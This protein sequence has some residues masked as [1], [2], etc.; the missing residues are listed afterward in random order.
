MSVVLLVAI[1]QKGSV[2]Q[3]IEYN[4]KLSHPWKSCNPKVKTLTK[5]EVIFLKPVCG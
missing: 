3:S 2:V 5:E 1:L 4:R